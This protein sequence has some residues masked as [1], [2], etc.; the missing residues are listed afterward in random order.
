MISFLFIFIHQIVDDFYAFVLALQRYPV[1]LCNSSRVR[2]WVPC[3]LLSFIVNQ[4]KV[5]LCH[6]IVLKHQESNICAE[7][8]FLTHFILYTLL[9]VLSNT[10]LV[11]S[12]ECSAVRSRSVNIYK[13]IL[14]WRCHVTLKHIAIFLHHRLMNHHSF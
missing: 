2:K 3:L 5:W 11:L 13:V 8:T 10:K 1:F 9:K 6:F 12:T 7:R 4:T 14:V